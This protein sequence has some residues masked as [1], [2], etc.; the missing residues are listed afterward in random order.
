MITLAMTGA[1]GALYGVRL[2]ERLLMAGRRVD[3]LISE[4]GR[5][6]LRQ[7][8][9]LDLADENGAGVVARLGAYLA[10]N[11]GHT[12]PLEGVRHFGMREWH[13]PIA[14]GSSGARA[15]VV[16][17]CSMGT[18]AAIAHGL[19]DTLIERAAD[20]ALK[21]RW[22]LILVTRETPL[23]T[24]HLENMLAATRAG[25][26]ILPASPGF[27]HRPER[28]EQ[29]IDFIVDR[30][31]MRLGVPVESPSHGWPVDPSDRR[32]PGNKS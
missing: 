5:E 6:L 13:A 9:G 28:I 14:S 22:P 30:I 15:M 20:V 25:A 27:Y 23:S 3:L 16:A 18:L 7:E 26:V 19:S 17:P 21:E 29:L 32:E 10:H 2:L 1:S 4:A 8:C 24:I 31:F 12:P 11:T